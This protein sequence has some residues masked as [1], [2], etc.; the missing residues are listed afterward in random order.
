MFGPAENGGGKDATVV[1]L[2]HPDNHDAPQRIRTWDD[3]DVF[4]NYVPIQ[5]TAWSIKP[6][7]TYTLA[8]RIV[9]MDGKADA[10]TIEQHWAAY[11]KWGKFRF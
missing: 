10:K 8:Y 2:C 6:G 4:L 11:A 5:E 1:I 7:E 3:G 9:V